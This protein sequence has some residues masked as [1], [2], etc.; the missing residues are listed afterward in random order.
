M[1]ER[2]RESGNEIEIQLS[3]KTAFELA[4]NYVSHK[5]M[6]GTCCACAN[7][8]MAAVPARAKQAPRMKLFG[9]K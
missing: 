3:N 9:K 6:T 4:I 1:S 7:I 5:T 8:A 2:D